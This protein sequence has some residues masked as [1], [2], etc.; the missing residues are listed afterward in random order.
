MRI[1]DWSSDVCSSDLA[2]SAALACPPPNC[3]AT[4]C[5]CPN[6]C[7]A[8]ALKRSSVSLP[9][10]RLPCAARLH[11]SSAACQGCVP[12][13]AAP[14]EALRRASPQAFQ[15]WHARASKPV[16]DPDP[17]SPRAA[18]PPCLLSLITSPLYR[19]TSSK[20]HDDRS[21]RLQDGGAEG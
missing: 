9:S 12:A 1:S 17:G 10:T 3:A 13:C 2:T 15:Y 21:R 4:C 5:I 20:P 7:P 6:H 18:P 8:C 16:P 14:G 11:Q 19:P